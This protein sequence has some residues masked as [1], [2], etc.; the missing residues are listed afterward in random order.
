[1]GTMKESM[2][3][4]ETQVVYKIN[5]SIYRF[6]NHMSS[7]IFVEY[8]EVQHLTKQIKQSEKKIM[9]ERFRNA[10]NQ[11]QRYLDKVMLDAKLGDRSIAL[12][13]GLFVYDKDLFDEDDEKAKE[14]QDMR[15]ITY[16]SNEDETE[17]D[18][19]EESFVEEQDEYEEQDEDLDMSY[20]E[21]NET[22]F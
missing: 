2:N 10:E 5:E 20:D 17:N 14:V 15:N 13:K 8:E 11:Q 22:L 3:E 7:I 21:D 16:G 4:M 19:Q 1:M 18:L 12:S 6:I 9:T